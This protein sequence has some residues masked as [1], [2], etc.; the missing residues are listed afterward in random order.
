[1]GVVCTLIDSWN[2]LQLRRGNKDTHYKEACIGL[3]YI[4]TG[5]RWTHIELVSLDN[6]GWRVV[7]VVVSLIVLVPFKALHI[8]VWREYMNVWNVHIQ[9][10]TR[11]ESNY[12]WGPHAKKWTECFPDWAG[13]SMVPSTNISY[14]KS[15]TIANHNS[16]L[17]AIIT[18]VAHSFKQ[19][20]L[21]IGNPIIK[22]QH[23]AFMHT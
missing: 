17:I 19:Y 5:E 1:M 10:M 14:R 15:L 11:M 13:A 2:L 3:S 16:R 18:S 22:I 20:I 4:A 6:L 12:N 23:A 8:S 21:Y 9:C 7:R